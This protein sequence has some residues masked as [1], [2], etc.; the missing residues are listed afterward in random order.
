MSGHSHARTIKHQKDITDQ[1]RGQIF[2]KMARVISIAVKDGGPNPETNTKLKVA[3]EQAKGFNLPKENIERA[4]K[5]ATGGEE[6]TNLTEVVFEAFGPG[7]IAIIVEGI[8]DNKN[9]TLG[10]IK[11]ILN[12]NQGKLAGEGSVKWLFEKRG[13]ITVKPD[14]QPKIKNKDDLELTAIEAGAE[15]VYWYD[16][17]LDV[18]TNPKDLDA[19]KKK[20]EEKEIKIDATSLDLMPKEEISVDKK[21]K[22]A[23][24]KLFE[25]LDENDAVQEIYSNL[26]L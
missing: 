11:Q 18:Y 16:N 5:Q 7:G 6:G 26:K 2:S 4:I 22:E 13:A 23:C 10:E 3:I 21:T 9:R 15:D 17:T 14:E 8:T 12:Q 20:L 24:Q 25:I 19:V 1:K